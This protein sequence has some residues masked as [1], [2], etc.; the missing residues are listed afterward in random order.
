MNL[1]NARI[2]VTGGSA[3]IGKAT[4]KLLVEAGA[5]V[6]ITGRNVEKLNRVAEEIGAI[7]VAFDVSDY[8]SIPTKAAETVEALGGI[9]VLVNNAGIGDF[10][11]MGDITI[12]HFERVFSTNVF[13]LTLLTQELVKHFKEQKNGHIINIASTAGVRGFARG[14]VYAASKFALRGMTECWRAELRPH[15]VRVILVNPSEVTTAFANEERIE[16]PDE[17]YK[18]RPLEIAYTIKATLE[19]DDRGFIPEVTVWATNPNR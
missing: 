2:L 14:T 8:A 4:A 3:G 18:L 13:G 5:K 17:A 6:V 7:A 11:L 1:S 19:M 12:E 16:R 15:N 9:D 10:P